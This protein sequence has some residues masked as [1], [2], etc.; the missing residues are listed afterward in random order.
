M[1]GTRFDRLLAG[2][3]LALILA[4]AALPAQAQT[5]A[6]Q[7]A[8]D[9]EITARVPLPEPA[10]VPPPTA[11]DVAAPATAAS[12]QAETSPTT[13]PQ[14]AAEKPAA[15][16]EPAPQ[17]AAEPAATVAAPAPQPTSEPAAAAAAPAPQPAPEKPAAVAAPA[18]AATPAPVPAATATA[19][20]PSTPAVTATA[21]AAPSLDQQVAEKLR[22]A[23][24][25]AGKRDKGI[26]T[27][28]AAHDFAPI[29]VS[30]GAM[31]ART[32]AAAAY[33]AKVDADGLDPADYVLP[34]VKPGSDPA[35]LAEIELKI[36]NTLLTYARHASNGRVHW[37]RISADIYYPSRDFEPAAALARIADAKD[38]AAALDGFN[39]QQPG[40]KAL[41]AKYAEAR[42]MSEDKAQARVPAGPVLKLVKDKKGKTTL[43]QDER[44][45]LLR[46][47]LGLA[48]V[49][50]DA[51]Y[52]Q[53]LVDAVKKYQN[54]NGLSASGQL[55][56]ATVDALNGAKRGRT[57]D[58][59][60]A[61]MERW[62]WLPQDLGKSYV[63]LNIPDFTLK[64]M[65]NGAQV[66][67]T[68]VVVGKPAKATPILSETM[69][70]ITVNPTW[71]VPPSIIYNE[72]LPALQ[73]DPTVLDR[74]GLKLTQNSD[75]SVHISQPPG[76]ANALG[77]LRFNFPNKFLVYQHDTPDKNL[78]GKEVRA[79][80]HGCMRVQDPAK[81]AEVLLGITLPHEGYTAEGIK[82]MFGSEERDIRFPTP[83]PVHITYQTA[84]VDDAG[85]L[86]LRDDIYGRDSRV[87]AALKGDDRRLAEVPIEHPQQSYA[88]PSVRLPERYAGANNNNSNS[89]GG[90]F[91]RLFGGWPSE[92]APAPVQNNRRTYSR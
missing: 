67:T 19:P 12:T 51:F 77:R 52:D 88:R 80:S 89:G 62:R 31:S 27:F 82:K 25:K 7:P 73:Q 23:L 42:G 68:R 57:T 41:K 48:A 60:L 28:Y 9:A 10:N 11:A 22:A 18:P 14:A 85:K 39:P 16:A 91:G 84:F 79:Y 21:P 70:Y 83:I 3:A 55:T 87:L 29:F 92:P 43:M 1:Q 54:A 38:V 65:K 69:K 81:Y 86:Q 59:I 74:M 50:N 56:A 58:I 13:V 44:V 75:G 36:T 49:T 53:P 63:M 20:A 72:Y 8:D 30:D 76:E 45:P 40:Y 66:W 2:T 61:N 71:N 33:L 15:V 5:A 35:A 46:E 78:F 6:A 24:A 34:D 64:V 32:K 90:F 37:S 4:A 17:P 47:R 26:E